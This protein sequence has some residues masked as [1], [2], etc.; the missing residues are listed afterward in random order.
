MQ[1]RR[2]HETREELKLA[3]FDA[4][5]DKHGFVTYACDQ[6]GIS[7]QTYCNWCQKD[8][9]FKEAAAQAIKAERERFTDIAEAALVNN[10]RDGKETSTIFYLKTQARNRGYVERQEIT[11]KDGESLFSKEALIAIAKEIAKDA[12]E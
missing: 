12:D 5:K 9:E 11:G 7:F 2:G 8:P 4:L 10:I 1:G 3:F 6:I